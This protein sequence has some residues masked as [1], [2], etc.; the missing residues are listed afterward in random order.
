MTLLGRLRG[1]EYLP[2]KDGREYGD[3]AQAERMD[4]VGEYYDALWAAR[5][6][7]QRRVQQ[8]AEKVAAMPDK[9]SRSAYMERVKASRPSEYE[10]LAQ[11]V[12]VAYR[13]R[14][15]ARQAALL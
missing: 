12:R 5:D 9:N 1:G 13:L 14:V 3:L 7:E 6:E 11:A 15:E 10:R 8:E 4:V 2:G